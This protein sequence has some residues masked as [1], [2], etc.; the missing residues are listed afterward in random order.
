MQN[1]ILAYGGLF[2]T[3]SALT[4]CFFLLSTKKNTLKNRK[5]VNIFCTTKLKVHDLSKEQTLYLDD[6]GNVHLLLL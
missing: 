3:G 1:E 5:N 2:Q 4:L 6:T